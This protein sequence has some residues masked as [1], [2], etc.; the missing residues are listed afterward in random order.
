WWPPRCHQH[1]RRE[2]VPHSVPGPEPR[3]G[4]RN[5]GARTGVVA[6]GHGRLLHRRA[7]PGTTGEPAMTTTRIPT[8]LP[9][10]RGVSA[11]LGSLGKAA[12]ITALVVFAGF[13]VYWMLG[14]SLGTET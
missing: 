4:R 6:A 3:T 7:D 13:P 11:R 12:L 2:C 14:T 8:D 10:R 1:P 5:R 9:R